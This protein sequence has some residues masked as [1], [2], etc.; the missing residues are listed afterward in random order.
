MKILII[1][2]GESNSGG[3]A[4]NSDCNPFELKPN[5]AVKIL[6]NNTMLFEDLAIGINNLLGHT[7]IS[8]SYPSGVIEGRHGWEVGLLRSVLLNS[9]L[10]EV[11]LVKTGQ[12]GSKIADWGGD[13]GYYTTAITR[14]KAAMALLG[15]DIFPIVWYTQ[16]INDASS[17]AE[18]IWRQK[19]IEY[20]NRLIA[21]IGLELPILFS[22]LPEIQIARNDSIARIVKTN[23]RYSL[24]SVKNATF[25]DA[26]HWDY[27]GMKLI[28]FRFF[29]KTI[30]L[31]N[32]G[33][34]MGNILQGASTEKFPGSFDN[35]LPSITISDEIAAL[36]GKPNLA[37]G[38]KLLTDLGL[39]ALIDR[40]LK[41]S[42]PLTVTLFGGATAASVTCLEYA[43][44]IILTVTGMNYPGGNNMICAIPVQVEDNFALTANKGYPY[45]VGNA[46]YLRSD[47]GVLLAD[48]Y[49]TLTLKKK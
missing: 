28:A 31:Y 32:K 24:I 43:T 27:K 40:M 41:T 37:L 30:E 3:L 4:F 18:D 21:D 26:N 44:E 1:F 48:Q 14:I 22:A 12:G 13:S 10:G 49:F 15:T 7:E 23:N 20:H 45:C 46:I 2:N 47:A 42:N 39:K 8:G 9:W 36:V 29:E 19:T 5:R 34:K 11:Y 35:P 33:K 6:N 17:V 16:G 25:W 38:E